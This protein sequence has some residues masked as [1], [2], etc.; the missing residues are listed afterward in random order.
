MSGLSRLLLLTYLSLSCGFTLKE[1][2]RYRDNDDGIDGLP[3][4]TDIDDLKAMIRR[5]YPDYNRHRGNKIENVTEENLCYCNYEMICDRPNACIKES[6]AA[7]YHAVEAVFNKI[8]GVMETS[9]LYGCAPLEDGSSGSH[10]TCNGYRSHHKTPLSLACCY[11]GDYCNLRIDPPPYENAYYPHSGL[12]SAQFASG[13]PWKTFIFAVFAIGLMATAVLCAYYYRHCQALPDM[14]DKSDKSTLETNLA[15]EID[16]E[17]ALIDMSSG[18]GTGEAILNDRTIAMVLEFENGIVGKGR[19]GEVRKATYRGSKVAVKTFY[20]T[21]E[22][23]WRNEHEIYHTK[24]LNHGNILKFV[25][26]DIS[27]VDCMTQMLLVTEF[28]ELGSLFDYLQNNS[29]SLEEGISLA[30]TAIC[31]IEHLHNSVIGTG[32]QCKPRI[33][34][35]DIKSKNVLVK[36]KGVCCIADFGLAV[37]LENDELIPRTVKICVGTKRYM[38]PEV[39]SGRLN[40]NNFD[41]FKLSDIYSFSLLLW[42]ILASVYPAHENESNSKVTSGSSNESQTAESAG[43]LM[44]T[45]ERTITNLHQ[46][47]NVQRNDESNVKAHGNLSGSSSGR[48]S[49]IMSNGSTELRL[50]GST[51]LS[52]GR[53]PF[54]NFVE[55]D[56]S[57]PDMA[58]VVCQEKRRPYVCKKWT[59]GSD[60]IVKSYCTLMT[61]CWSEEPNSRHA[62]LK[63]KMT[64]FDLLSKMETMLGSRQSG[65]RQEDSNRS[66]DSGYSSRE[67]PSHSLK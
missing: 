48:G 63:I 21:E 34:H 5:L 65:K 43:G 29:V 8:S 30:Y 16:E 41:A 6:K 28:H 46:T 54:E 7:C 58:R 23:S 44:A 47:V 2:S 33:A 56:P 55:S 42:E 20:T 39:L 18:S 27:S 17:K 3:E 22:E 38:S 45:Y 62:A 35:R 61:E 13:L 50:N 12:D 67:N 9:H 14:L 26:A 1:N 36:R 64:L 24:M 53:L 51:E 40:P 60:P 11:E 25:A 52:K 49:S 59:D 4:H 19:Y 57:I 10:L 66:G 32:N 37:R 15:S 31:G